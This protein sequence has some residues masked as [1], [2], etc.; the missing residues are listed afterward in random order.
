M[1]LADGFLMPVTA[2]QHAF[3]HEVITILEKVVKEIMEPKSLIYFSAIWISFFA[4]FFIK[5]LSIQMDS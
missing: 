1:T 2:S 5:E 3:L 4:I